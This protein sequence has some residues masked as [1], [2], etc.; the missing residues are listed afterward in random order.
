MV[1]SIYK[2]DEIFGL[3]GLVLAKKLEESNY[4][5]V[6]VS[7]GEILTDSFGKPII[8]RG[9]TPRYVSRAVKTFRD[10]GYDVTIA[11]TNWK[12]AFNS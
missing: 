2:R 7:G 6:Y 9:L 4:T 12:T 8:T 11:K 5:S 3:N 1:I 10:L